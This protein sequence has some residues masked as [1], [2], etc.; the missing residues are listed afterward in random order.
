MTDPELRVGGKAG[1]L[2]VGNQ[3]NTTVFQLGAEVLLRYRFGLYAYATYTLGA[4]FTPAD[5]G[6]QGT[7]GDGLG[8]SAGLSFNW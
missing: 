1:A 6:N 5:G 7:L 4:D 2:I 8:A 3:G